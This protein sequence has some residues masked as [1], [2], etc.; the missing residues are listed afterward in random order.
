MSFYT[1]LVAWDEVHF[2][3]VEI[4]EQFKL[5]GQPITVINSGNM[6][7]DHWDNVG[8]IRYYRQFYH[9]LKSFDPAYDYMAF[10]CG[11]VS[12]DR[13]SNVID[14]A[15]YV[16]K[17]YNNTGLYAPHLTHEPW[18]EGA[19]K[20][21]EAEDQ[22]N[23]SIQTDGIFVFIRKDIVQTMLDYFDFLN[24]EIK[25][26][27]MKSG[28]GLDM[29][30]SSIA[31]IN[32][33]SILRDKMHVPNHPAGS[34]Y[35]HSRATEEMNIMLSNF[36]KFIEQSGLDQELYKKMHGKIYGRMSHQ[37]NC[38]SVTDFYTHFNLI[39]RKPI[40]YHVIYINDERKE[41]RDQIHKIVNGNLRNIFSL[42]ANLTEEIDKFYTNN[43]SFKIAW[44]GFKLGELG[45][46]ASHYCAWNY[47]ID[48]DLDSLLVFEDDVVMHD[49]FMEK[50][51]TIVDN[52]PED[53]DVMSVFVDPNQY[54]RYRPDHRI[55]DY[56]ARG[57]Q[58]WSTLCYIV[59][60]QGA[61]KLVQYVNSVGMDHPTDWFIFR[62]GHKG[63]FNVYTVLPQFPSPLEID[64]SYESQVQ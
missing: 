42:N 60:R 38:K 13:W 15:N 56:I 23:I 61:N 18:S 57:Y 44:E 64:H 40:D 32:G 63:I 58:D 55:N 45:N 37:E 33:L 22:L 14:R 54:P 35:D 50:Y 48:N 11:D 36:Y 1:Y 16:L 29:I 24:K 46:F 17:K 6:K 39:N 62:K 25:L 2:N 43:N 7:R 8:D 12:S 34:S 49:D 28:W 27:E 21:A 20:I 30:W 51:N 4:E 10:L 52:L 47:V 19:S 41:N 26:S 9:A 31:I 53:Y 5:S 59:S 3:S